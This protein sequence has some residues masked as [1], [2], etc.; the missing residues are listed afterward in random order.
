MFTF[1]SAARA[2]LRSRG[3]GDEGAAL[4]VVM[5]SILLVGALSVLILGVV[6]AQV[7]PTASAQKRVTTL[8]AAQAGV[9]AAVSELRSVTLSL[10]A[11]GQTSVATTGSKKDLP[12]ALSGTVG[13]SSNVAATSNVG[14]QVTIGYYDADP[15]SMSLAEQKLH[16]IPCTTGGS[17]PGPKFIPAFALVDSLGTSTQTLPGETAAVGD[18]R[19]KS[20]YTFKLDNNNTPGGR[21]LSL[22]LGFCLAADTA[23]AGSSITYVKKSSGCVS[24]AAT[25]K[26]QKWF[27]ATD[28]TIKL[29]STLPQVAGAA[30]TTLCIEGSTGGNVEAKLRPCDKTNPAQ[31]WS[32]EGG[33]R[34]RGQN[35]NNTNYGNACL[36]SGASD[37]ADSSI[38]GKKLLSG[39]GGCSIGDQ[40]R[41]SF[42]PEP[43]VGAGAASVDTKQ[44]VN[45]YE[46]GRCMDVTNQ[47]FAS[48]QM[49]VYPCKQDPSGGSKLAWNHKWYYTEDSEAPQVIYVVNGNDKRCLTASGAA[50][51]DGDVVF[52]TCDGSAAQQFVRYNDKP[53]YTDS[54]TFRD[55]AGRCLAIGPKWGSTDF[56]TIVSRTCNGGA[57]QKWNAKNDVVIPG[58]SN[59]R[60]VNRV[61]TP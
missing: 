25:D 51:V 43:T 57:A 22:G 49:I 44:I 35:A 42:A 19:V 60:E 32:Y 54:F 26:L 58:V 39:S 24:T 52:K 48:T 14:Y 16:E 17:T 13:S 2:R 28:Y 59:T 41:G 3:A 27:Y 61:S 4:V 23:T 45:Y 33:A 18:R 40:A 36:W 9:D 46:F 38:Q 53:D 34:F 20:L 50:V 56:S 11:D 5:I 30:A 15:T 55:F 10:T 31:L 29:A 6:T 37:N 21:M 8:S 47:T 7:L 12:C 1:F